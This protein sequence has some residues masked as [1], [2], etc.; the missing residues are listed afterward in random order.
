MIDGQQ[1]LATTSILLA[2]VR[3]T[4]KSKGED[5]YARSTQQEYLG[6]FDR[7]A[8]ID[9]PQLILNTDDR[10]FFDRK[11]V[12]EEAVEPTTYSQQLIKSGSSQMRV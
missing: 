5:A 2:A 11:V 10:D 7:R 1:R 12:L 6:R 3:D 9:Q 4:Y 8:G